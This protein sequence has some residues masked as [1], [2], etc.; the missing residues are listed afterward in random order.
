MFGR[1]GYSSW[2]QG[3]VRGVGSKAG[4]LGVDGVGDV[5]GA[6]LSLPGFPLSFFLQDP[7]SY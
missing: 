5:E 7:S 4:V 2:G 3:G 6:S 1:R